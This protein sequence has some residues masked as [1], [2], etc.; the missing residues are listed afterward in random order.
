MGDAL[1]EIDQDNAAMFANDVAV[2]L[3]E[4]GRRQ[5]ALAR[6]EQNLHRF[7]DDMWTH[8]HAGDVHLALA[9]Q[10]SAERSFRDAITVARW[11]GD[12]DGIADA[13]E[14]LARLFADQPGREPEAAAAEREPVPRVVNGLGL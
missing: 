10:P 4:A 11:Q 12:V 9:D 8:I 7:P 3:A 2:I 5:Q 6:V 1:A 13:N 14:R